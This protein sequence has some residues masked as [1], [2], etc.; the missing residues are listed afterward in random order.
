MDEDAD[1]L[2]WE[3]DQTV[4]AKVLCF[5]KHRGH[6]Y[7][8]VARTDAR[9]CR[10]VRDVSNPTG[11]LHDLQR[12]LRLRTSVDV[13]TAPAVAPRAFRIQL[14]F[15]LPDELV[16]HVLLHLP[17][18]ALLQVPAACRA[19]HDATRC[20]SWSRLVTTAMARRRA[21]VALF[22][23]ARGMED[24]DAAVRRFYGIPEGWR[25][26]GIRFGASGALEGVA[27][28]VQ[29]A[30]LVASPTSRD[31]YVS[32]RKE[33]RL[34]ILQWRRKN[35]AMVNEPSHANVAKFHAANERLRRALCAAIDVFLDRDTPVPWCVSVE[36]SW[37]IF[38]WDEDFELPAAV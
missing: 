16:Q 5:G 1:A 22:W 32:T 25:V 20:D 31:A 35:S 28:T 9:Y 4:G 12:Y 23:P 21:A 6:T 37:K 7:A 38:A 2:L 13:H 18:Y 8:H 11:H 3:L 36:I 33:V 27:D 17:L 29:L 30:A 15:G 34:A 26:P 19:L 24:H 14:L 10:W